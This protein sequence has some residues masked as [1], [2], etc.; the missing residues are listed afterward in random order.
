MQPEPELG[1]IYDNSIPSADTARCFSCM[2]RLYEAI[3]PVL[4]NI[5]KKPRNFTDECDEESLDPSRV[6]VVN[7]PTI[8][9]SMVEEPNIGGIRVKGYIRGCMNDVLIGGFNQ[10]IVGWYRWMHRDSCK[11]YRK[12]ELFMLPGGIG[13]DS[14][15]EV[16]TCYA[17]HCNGSGSGS[18]RPR[19]LAIIIALILMLRWT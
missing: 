13:D 14:Q 3:W 16:C 4:S 9:V 17:D 10:T 12:K 7:C 18:E 19:N 8:C 2:S 1:Y 6:P 5:Y 15:I 11:A